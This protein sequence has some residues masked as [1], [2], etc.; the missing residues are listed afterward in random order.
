MFKLGATGKG[1]HF[2]LTEGVLTPLLFWHSAAGLTM[3]LSGRTVTHRETGHQWF[4]EIAV[5]RDGVNVLRAVAH[6]PTPRPTHGY[7][8]DNATEARSQAAEA[9]HETGPL[10]VQLD[11]TP[12]RS[13][14][15]SSEVQ[16][17]SKRAALTVSLTNHQRKLRVE[18]STLQGPKRTGEDWSRGGLVLELVSARAAK[19]DTS[20]KE[21][22]AKYHHLNLH[23][24]SGIPVGATGAFAELAGSQPMSEHVRALLKRPESARRSR[25]RRH[26]GSDA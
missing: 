5:A 15:L 20:S 24:V 1:L 6:D 23:L 14:N 2:W 3:E 4:K 9:E 18:A 12:V 8:L 16:L 19:F 7:W 25:R 13:S 11:E 17:R 26:R 22:A 10:E 21:A